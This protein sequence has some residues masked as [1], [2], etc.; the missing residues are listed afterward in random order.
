MNPLALYRKN[1]VQLEDIS[2]TKIQPGDALLLHGEWEKFHI[3]QRKPDLVFTEHIKGEIM[4][5]EK[6]RGLPLPA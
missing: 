3:L 5:P 1:S 6:K 2:V 4:H